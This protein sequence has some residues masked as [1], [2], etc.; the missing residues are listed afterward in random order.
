MGCGGGMARITYFAKLGPQKRDV[1]TAPRR[2][3]V[4]TRPPSRVMLV[5]CVENQAE[6]DAVVGWLALR[7][8][9]K[10]AL[11]KRDVTTT[12]RRFPVFTRSPLRLMLVWCVETQSEWD[13]AVVWL[14]LRF[15]AKW[16]LE[17]RDVTTTPRRFPVFTR[18]PSR[19]MLVWCVET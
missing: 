13:A 7:F 14:A 4:F 3:P 12:P 15:S 6:W 11:E 16:A 1:T 2:L 8:F 17:K 19:V 10:W 9:A 5:W 18:S